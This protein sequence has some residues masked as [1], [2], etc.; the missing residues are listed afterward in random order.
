MDGTKIVVSILPLA[1]VVATVYWLVF[2]FS[3]ERE[4]PD[5]D[6]NGKTNQDKA[7]FSFQAVV[8]LIALY[9]LLHK[10]TDVLMA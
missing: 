5:A 3:Y 7:T 10:H 9:F 6:S 1:A 2:A 8:A 4:G